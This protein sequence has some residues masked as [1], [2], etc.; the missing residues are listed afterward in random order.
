MAVVCLHDKE[1]IETFLR[2]N[3]FLHL[4]EI[5]DLDDFF[6][7][8]T[9]W[10]ALKEQQRIS[11]TALFYTAPQV[12]VLL[13]ICEEPA[14]TMRAL[15]S[16]IKHLLP[17]RLYAHL[18]GDLATVFADDYHVESHGLHY[19][20]ALL[21]KT[22]LDSI[23]DA[24]VVPLTVAHMRELEALYNVS[25]P[26]N[27]FDP[28]MLETGR[29]YGIRRDTRGARDASLVCVAGIHVYS[30]RYKVA[31][32]GNVTTHPDFRGR[33]LGTAACARLCKELLREVDHIGLNVKADNAGAIAC[34]E[35]LGFERIA[36][37]EEYSLELKPIRLS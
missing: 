37:Y 9:T 36:T 11:Q 5:G 31:V 27:S 10:F 12:P 19:K 32:L 33:G 20:M 1:Q 3:T 24:S 25:Y 15:L 7:Q 18:N 23:D 4:Y 21:D 30:P 13:G 8:Y 28:R 29:Y 17:K 34:Y 6:W 35:R 22:R 16:A 26:G 14:A 2:G